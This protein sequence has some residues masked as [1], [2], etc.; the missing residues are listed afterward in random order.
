MQINFGIYFSVDLVFY[1]DSLMKV[2]RGVDK[3]Y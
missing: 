1:R 2:Y 3:I